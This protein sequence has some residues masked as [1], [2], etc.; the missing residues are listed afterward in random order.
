MCCPG[1]IL[2]NALQLFGEIEWGRSGII[3]TKDNNWNYPPSVVW[4][5][6]DRV[7]K[8][9]KAIVKAVNSFQGNVKWTII[10]SGRNWSISPRSLERFLEDTE[11]E[12]GVDPDAVFASQHPEIGLMANKD[13][14]QLAEHIKKTVQEALGESIN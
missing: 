6:K 2:T 12:P 9:E 7:E 11:F 14:P 5:Y 3:I 8:V 1:E 4:R 10:F 13:L